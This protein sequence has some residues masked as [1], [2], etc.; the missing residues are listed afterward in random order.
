MVQEITPERLAARAACQAN[1]DHL[2]EKAGR[3]VYW[4]HPTLNVIMA[5]WTM[6]GDT[7]LI[8][9]DTE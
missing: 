7:F 6:P 2:N 5:D 8:S 1:L 9:V 4:L 3:R